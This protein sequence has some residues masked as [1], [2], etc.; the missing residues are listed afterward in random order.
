MKNENHY[1]VMDLRSPYKILNHISVIDRKKE[2]FNL[3]APFL[4]KYLRTEIEARYETIIDE[5]ANATK[6]SQES[7]RADFVDFVCNTN[8]EIHM[9]DICNLSCTYCSFGRTMNSLNENQIHDAIKLLKPKAITISGGGENTLHPEFTSILAMIK[10]EAPDVQIGLITNGVIT[11]RD[12]I[13][14]ELDWIRVS[15]DAPDAEMYKKLKGVDRF[16]STID[17]I[18]YYL[19]E[20][21]IA[22]VGVGYLFSRDNFSGI[23]ESLTLL[24]RLKKF[25]MFVDIGII[26]MTPRTTPNEYINQMRYLYEYGFMNSFAFLSNVRVYKGT[27]LF[28]MLD[29]SKMLINPIS[30][31]EYTYKYE[32]IELG[33]MYTYMKTYLMK[34][35]ST[36]R[37]SRK[38]YYWAKAMPTFV[39]ILLKNNEMDSLNL[40]RLYKLNDDLKSIMNEINERNYAWVNEMFELMQKGWSDKKAQTICE[41]SWNTYILEG[42]KDRYT[43]VELLLYKLLVRYQPNLVM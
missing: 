12:S 8:L 30:L 7:I 15:L 37:Y 21:K 18:R 17:S 14:D 29:E 3:Y 2:I 27:K 13:M 41:A 26:S 39:Q 16:N 1:S 24:D 4:K 38:M 36:V 25:P 32:N 6:L 23:Y 40:R 19:N 43:S 9:T 42:I 28:K 11:C 31:F 35:S 5:I 22:N 10:K 34:L 20:T 33:R